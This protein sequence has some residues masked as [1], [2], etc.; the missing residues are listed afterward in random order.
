MTI[1]GKKNSKQM[2]EKDAKP[3][4]V[5][6]RQPFDMTPGSPEG[7]TLTDKYFP[8]DGQ[9]AEKNMTTVSVSDE[10]FWTNK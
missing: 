10:E 3:K 2:I 7:Q 6:S 9:L 8:A 4:P 1:N 5:K